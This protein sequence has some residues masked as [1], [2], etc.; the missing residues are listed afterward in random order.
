MS[1]IINYF[2]VRS[3]CIKHDNAIGER[4]LANRKLKVI[5]AGKARDIVL[6]K[7]YSSKHHA[8]AE[9]CKCADLQFV[10]LSR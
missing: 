1:S 9:F 8:A 6:N 10:L 5:R 7:T 2:V 3:V 4:Y